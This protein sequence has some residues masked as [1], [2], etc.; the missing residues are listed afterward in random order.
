MITQCAMNACFW[1]EILDTPAQSRKDTGKLMSE[2]HMASKLGFDEPR[3]AKIKKACLMAGD[4]EF[5][6]YD[7]ELVLYKVIVDQ[8]FSSARRGIIS[9]L[10][11]AALGKKALV[12]FVL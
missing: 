5:D 10:C 4:W 9:M 1:A 6:P 2:A 11:V 8:E 7:D 3:I 12:V